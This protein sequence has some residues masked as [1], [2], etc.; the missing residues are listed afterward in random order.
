M[1]TYAG[2]ICLYVAQPQTVPGVSPEG[3]SLRDAQHY[4]DRARYLDQDNMVATAWSD[5]VR[6]DARTRQLEL[7]RVFHRSQISPRREKIE[8]PLCLMTKPWTLKPITV[9]A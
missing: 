6:T 1:H 5:A 4:F 2:L 8:R 9:N 3:R 7:R